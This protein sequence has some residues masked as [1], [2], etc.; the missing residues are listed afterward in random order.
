ML[1]IRYLGGGKYEKPL[2]YVIDK[3]KRLLIPFVIVGLFFE[4][5]IKIASGYFDISNGL[6]SFY[7][8]FQSQFLLKGNN[9][10]WFCISLFGCLITVFLVQKTIRTHWFLKLVLFFT[11]Y[12]FKSQ[13]TNPFIFLIAVNAIWVYL[14]CIWYEYRDSINEW[15]SRHNYL[16]ILSIVVLIYAEKKTFLCFDENVL[17]PYRFV[18]MLSGF[19]LLYSIALLPAVQKKLGNSQVLNVFNRYTMG[20]YLYTDPLNYLILFLYYQ[21]L[22]IEAFG[23]EFV[24]LTLL[25][26]RTIGLIIVAYCICK[27][28]DHFKVKYLF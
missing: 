18:A 10:L 15:V 6:Q 4:I 5:P 21:V 17:I 20:F 22:G 2:L 27:M 7:S 9:Y 19:Y 14:G 12:L 1:P 24:A 25:I 28:L 3:A 16:I 13:C 26:A 23:S 11:V 8:I